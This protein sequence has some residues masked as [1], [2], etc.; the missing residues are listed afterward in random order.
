MENKIDKNI[1]VNIFYEEIATHF[2]VRGPITVNKETHPELKGM[3]KKEMINYIEE[4]VFRMKAVNG[5][6]YQ[7]LDQELSDSNLIRD[8][9]YTDTVKFGFE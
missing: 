2:I 7:T 9:S 1:D 3:S 8:K 6:R 4:N 5:E